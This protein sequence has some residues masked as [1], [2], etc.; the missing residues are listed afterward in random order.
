MN[1]QQLPDHLINQIAAG[2]VVERPA[3][4]I[5]ELIENSLDAGA[6]RIEVDLEQGGIEL[7]RVRDNGSGIVADQLPLAVARHATSKIASLK[8]LQN[9]TSMGFRGEALPS[10]ASVSRMTI[11]TCTADALQGVKLSY[12]VDGA[13]DIRPDPHTHGT[14]IEVRELFYNVPARRKFLRTARTEFTHAQNLLQKLAL[15]NFHCE[16]VLNHN[17]RKVSRWPAAASRAQKEQRL[18]FICGS[19]FVQ[20]LRYIE[21][22]ALG[23]GLHGWVAEPTFNRS[24]TD[25]Q[26]FYVNS[27]SVKDR[28]IAHAIKQAYRDLIYH[29]RH[30]AYVLYLQLPAQL[31]DVNVHPG[32]HEVRFRESQTVHR[33]VRKSIEDALSSLK[34]ASVAPTQV[35]VGLEMENK[36]EQAEIELSDRSTL[37]SKSSSILSDWS[38]SAR[39]KNIGSVKE[40]F[41]GF[42]KLSANQSYDN[43]REY[44]SNIDASIDGTQSTSDKAIPPLGFALA[45]LHDIYILAQNQVGIVLVD[46]HAAHERITYE[47]LKTNFHNRGRVQSQPLLVPIEISVSET[48]ADAWEAHQETLESLGLVLQRRGP[49][50]LSVREVPTILIKSD[51]TVLVRDVLSDLIEFGSSDRITEQINNMLSTMACHGS[52]R[53]NRHLSIAEMNALLRD[54]ETTENSGQ[55]NHGRPTWTQLS[56]KQLDKL[57]LRGR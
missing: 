56:L 27:R 10:I 38:S 19:E 28:V 34:P 55:C 6:T 49:S 45:H 1:I 50:R 5:K 22:E 31:V 14:T 42:T 43:T 8:D 18:G 3:S 12:L 15:A 21:A 48:E 16:F 2:E 46:A 52:V 24:Q 35:K 32:K 11:R 26:Y 23:L 9:V 51:A 47:K 54:I 40:Q 4:I 13:H 39:S 57:F 37:A 44:V 36:V 29:Q 7:I 20:H 17:G 30:P 53:A 25:M 33:F 41:D